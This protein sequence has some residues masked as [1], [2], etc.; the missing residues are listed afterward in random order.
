M[1]GYGALWVVY[2][3]FK[4]ITS[5]SGM[6][7][8]DFKL[9]AM[10]GAWAGWEAL[11]EIIL[12]SSCAGAVAGVGLFLSRRRQEQGRAEEQDASS[13]VGVLATPIPFG[14]FLALAGWLSLLW[15]PGLFGGLASLAQGP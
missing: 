8:G 11:L 6:G 9:L 12:L 5:R 3:V 13:P 7:F 14:P 1:L 10:L 2:S 15:G 4:L